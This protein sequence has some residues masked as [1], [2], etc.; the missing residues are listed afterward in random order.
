MRILTAKRLSQ[1]ERAIKAR[2]LAQL[3][4]VDPENAALY[5]YEFLDLIGFDPNDGQR[6][7]FDAWLSGNRRLIG[8]VGRRGGKTAAAG[9]MGAWE[10]LKDNGNGWVIAPTHKLNAR[11]WEFFHKAL[12]SDGPIH[13]MMPKSLGL[14]MKPIAQNRATDKQSGSIEMP[15]GSRAVGGSTSGKGI[16]SLVGD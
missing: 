9:L 14:G 4:A 11:F 1:N 8:R 16:E 15:W 6:E 7:L 3:A 5:F 10:T 12:C 2:V 13:P